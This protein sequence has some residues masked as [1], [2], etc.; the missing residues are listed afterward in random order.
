MNIIKKTIKYLGIFLILLLFGLGIFIYSSGP[1]LPDHADKT[2]EN[3]IKNPLPELIKGETGYANSNGLKI[4]YESVT[5]KGNSKGVILLIMGIS[6]DAMGWPPKFI[7]SFTEAGFQVIRYD[8]RGTGLSDWM[9]DFDEDNPYSLLDMAS[10]AIAVLDTLGI[11]KAN[12]LGVSMGGMIAQELAIHYPKRCNSLTSIMSS[13]HI[14]DPEIKPIS[15]QTAFEL[16]KT[17]IKYSIFSSEKNMAKLHIA[18]R[19]IL[20][21][22]SSQEINIKSLSEQVIYNIRQRKGYNPNVSKQH[23]TAVFQSGSRYK[24]LEKLALPTLI[25]HGKNDPFIP[26]EHGKKCVSLIPN[27]DSLWLDNVGHD[28]PDAT[29]PVISEK[30]IQFIK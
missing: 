25:I 22:N 24:A 27:A 23:Q 5:P 15:S 12:I 21:G 8:H 16:I 17:A 11:E 20:R 13:G 3:V 7:Q 18:S 28:I 26:I 29:I 10:D 9:D 30:I 6:N 4:W 14:M 19:I 2:I 1:K